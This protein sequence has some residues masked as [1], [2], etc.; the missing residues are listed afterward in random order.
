[1]SQISQGGGG[2][3]RINSRPSNIAK[4]V[5]QAVTATGVAWPMPTSEVE[6]LITGFEQAG[7]SWNV[8][9]QQFQMAGYTSPQ[10]VATQ[11]A[12]AGWSKQRISA[13]FGFT[14]TWL[15][16]LFSQLAQGVYFFIPGG[17][18]ARV[19]AGAGGGAAAGAG[20]AGAGAAGAAEGAGVTAAEAGAAGAGAGATAS[21]AINYA[22]KALST[23][24]GLVKVGGIAA[25]LVDPHFLF[26][27][28]KIVGGLLLGYLAVR[29]LAAVGGSGG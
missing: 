11:L 1:M 6:Q 8:Q 15:D 28:V 19:A 27:I 23:L 3:N 2:G 25:L 13:A 22:S 29:Q 4:C 16:S 14:P 10:E 9:W 17:I 20:A 21:T 24:S 26:R 18:G 5:G 7:Y 12:S